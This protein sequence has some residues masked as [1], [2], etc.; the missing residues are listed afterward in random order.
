[1]TTVPD[2]IGYLVNSTHVSCMNC[3]PTTHGLAAYKVSVSPLFR[4]NIGD[5]E[6]TCHVCHKVIVGGKTALWPEL[7]SE[8]G[9]ASAYA[10]SVR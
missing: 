4:E 7:F 8:H 5:Y 3:G 10:S 9:N 6:Q 2:Q 1:M